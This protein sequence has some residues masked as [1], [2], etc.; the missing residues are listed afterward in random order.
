MKNLIKTYGKYA[1]KW[2]A[3]S[4]SNQEIVASGDS[5]KEVENKIKLSKSIYKDL[6]ITFVTPLDGSLAP[7]ANN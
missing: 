4:I 2:V 5:V 7:Y 1:G 3:L 6:V